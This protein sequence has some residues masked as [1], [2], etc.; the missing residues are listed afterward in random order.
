VELADFDY[1]GVQASLKLMALLDLDPPWKMW[2]RI[3]DHPH[4]VAKVPERPMASVVPQISLRTES[5]W[6]PN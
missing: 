6:G 5:N 3:A 4:V 1:R 2:R